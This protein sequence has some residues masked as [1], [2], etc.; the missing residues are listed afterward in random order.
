LQPNVLLVA[1]EDER[2]LQF[3]KKTTAA[4]EQEEH[5]NNPYRYYQNKQATTRGSENAFHTRG[6]SI[7]HTANKETASLVLES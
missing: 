1:R 6:K 4:Y 2:K 5:N 7:P 3:I